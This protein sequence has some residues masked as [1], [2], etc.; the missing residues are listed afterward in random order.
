M[1]APCAVDARGTCLWA[2]SRDGTQP[3]GATAPRAAA[4]GAAK[5]HLASLLLGG[6]G[7][8][9]IPT[10]YTLQ[11]SPQ[12]DPEP[13]HEQRAQVRSAWRHGHRHG[14]RWCGDSAIAAAI[15]V[16]EDVDVP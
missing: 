7:T 5:I 2:A 4:A 12:H 15:G 10:L 9:P 8:R 14:V 11:R 3:R 16:A 6:W 13:L 1:V